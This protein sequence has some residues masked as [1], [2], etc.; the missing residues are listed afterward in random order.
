MGMNPMDAAHIEGNSYD[1]DSCSLCASECSHSSNGRSKGD[2]AEVCNT[3]LLKVTGPNK[4]NFICEWTCTNGDVTFMTDSTSAFKCR[5]DAEEPVD[6]N[7][8]R[9][10]SEPDCLDTCAKSACTAGEGEKS[11]KSICRHIASAAMDA[12]QA[13]CME[14]NGTSPTSEGEGFTP[15]EQRSLSAGSIIGIVAYICCCCV[16]PVLAKAK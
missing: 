2:E 12:G 15:L 8:T 16:C 9:G 4:G 10:Q 14:P 11:C 13:V 6:I 7:L 1:A 5:G 3:E